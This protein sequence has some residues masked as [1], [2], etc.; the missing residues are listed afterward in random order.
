MKSVSFN[1]IKS[2][3]IKI[4]GFCCLIALAPGFVSSSVD[5]KKTSSEVN[6][7]ERGNSLLIKNYEEKNGLLL[8]KTEI[9]RPLMSEI[10]PEYL[11]KKAD[12]NSVQAFMLSG[13]RYFPF[14]IAGIGVDENGVKRVYLY[15]IDGKIKPKDSIE[16][17]REN[18]HQ[19]VI[20]A[21]PEHK[22]VYEENKETFTGALWQKDDS[23]LSFSV[24]SDE[25]R[26]TLYSLKISNIKSG[27]NL[28]VSAYSGLHEIADK[29]DNE[30]RLTELQ[31]PVKCQGEITNYKLRDGQPSY[32][33]R[34]DE[35][36][37]FLNS[38]E[39]KELKLR[40]CPPPYDTQDSVILLKQLMEETLSASIQ[41]G[42]PYINS[43]A[44]V[45][46]AS[47]QDEANAVFVTSSDTPYSTQN[48]V[49]ACKQTSESISLTLNQ[50]RWYKTTSPTKR[51]YEPLC[52]YNAT[53]QHCECPDENGNWKPVELALYQLAPDS[54]L[55]WQTPSELELKDFVPANSLDNDIPVYCQCN[56]ELGV[57]TL[58]E[59]S[60]CNIPSGEQLYCETDSV[61]YYKN[62]M[63]PAPTTQEGTTADFDPT[64]GMSAET[65]YAENS[66]QW[67][68]QD[69]F[70]ISTGVVAV[71]L[72]VAC[73][74]YCIIKD[75]FNADAY[76]KNF[77]QKYYKAAP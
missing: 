61:F 42:Q 4:F 3:H 1:L 13:E 66:E 33:N 32:Q 67:S 35:Y 74:L 26:I 59:L 63:S 9:K 21:F 55:V 72:S 52:L 51:D 11:T 54:N 10:Y 60:T 38:K 73:T 71:A 62:F 6:E 50:W 40:F 2:R 49:W 17:R 23:G 64:R 46:I 65:P 68:I 5:I 12:F 43:K 18:F 77:Q 24:S 58:G 22:R 41:E 27:G 34:M 15:K 75:P 20:F 57:T 44:V 37:E 19:E 8:Q 31:D 29:R 45:P 70:W 56:D 16:S 48:A 14:Q 53:E 39:Y 28:W 30:W 36:D 25:P 7:N 69:I 76:T 47:D